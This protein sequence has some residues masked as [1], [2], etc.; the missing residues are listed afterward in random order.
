MSLHSAE[1]IPTGSRSLHRVGSP[2]LFR[3]SSTQELC[4]LLAAHPDTVL[5][6]GGLDVVNRMKE[7]SRPP[8]LTLLQGV[9]DLARVACPEGGP[10]EIGAMVSHDTLAGHALVRQHLPDLAA[11]W[12]RIANIRIRMQGTIGGNLCAGAPGYE[13]AVL[14]AVLGAEAGVIGSDGAAAAQP[15]GSEHGEAF[16]L[17]R[18][19]CVTSLRLITARAGTRRRL[20]YHRGL[21]PALWLALGVDVDLQAGR[22]ISAR[23]ALGGL[24]AGP[25]LRHPPM[26]GMPL[27]EL[28]RCAVDIAQATLATPGALAQPTLPWHGRAGYRE[29]VAPVLLA[30]LIAA[31]AA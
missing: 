18:G 6:G 1:G 30:R 10:L 15:V 16:T 23:V 20:L 27:A 8:S 19:H 12:D 21:R 7:D 17:R 14:L 24:H 11:A 13:A 3:P 31:V 4:A 9:A 25:L 26:A 2:A 22:V 28:P 29:K 5:V